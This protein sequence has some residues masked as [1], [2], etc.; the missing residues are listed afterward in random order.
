MVKQ[1]SSQLVYD[2]NQIPVR[3]SH[4]MVQKQIKSQRERIDVLFM[5]KMKKPAQTCQERG[6]LEQTLHSLRHEMSAAM[7]QG[8]RSTG[9]TL[10]GTMESRDVT[11]AEGLSPAPREET[12]VRQCHKPQRGAPAPTSA[13]GTVTFTEE[14]HPCQIRGKYCGHTGAE[15]ARTSLSPARTS[16][17]ESNP[18]VAE[19]TV[20]RR[21]AVSETLSETGENSNAKVSGGGRRPLRGLREARPPKPGKTL[22][23]FEENV[24]LKDKEA[25]SQAAASEAEKRSCFANNYVLATNGNHLALFN[26]SR[27]PRRPRPALRLAAWAAV[28]RHSEDRQTASSRMS[29]AR[30][31]QEQKTAQFLRYTESVHWRSDEKCPKV[32]G[33]MNQP[34][35][36]AEKMEALRQPKSTMSSVASRMKAI[37]AILKN[38]QLPIRCPRH[39]EAGG[40]NPECKRKESSVI[41]VFPNLK[42]P[43]RREPLRQPIKKINSAASRLKAIN[44]MHKSQSNLLG[45]P[46]QQEAALVAYDMQWRETP[47]CDGKN[48]D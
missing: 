16:E 25:L 43:Q 12:G 39:L 40:P 29:D 23:L 1:Q 48:K 45:W 31:Q 11:P 17:P 3:T 30:C 21:R 4:V 19:S 38:Q 27:F 37:N 41:Q 24:S 33:G 47:E 5:S 34:F 36:A 15:S 10:A 2:T 28:R 9:K 22:Q 18:G 6:W 35:I 46:N 7:S 13:T 44:E 42:E 14:T 32:E 26:P 20:K 8:E